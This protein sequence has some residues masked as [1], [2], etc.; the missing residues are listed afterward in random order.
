LR[1]QQGMA[2][3]NRACVPTPP[4]SDTEIR[5]VAATRRAYLLALI[6]FA[7]IVRRLREFLPV[8]GLPM[9]WRKS[10]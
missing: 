1:S 9:Q 3:S 2:R 4:G 5:I 7:R 10:P 8:C 6:V